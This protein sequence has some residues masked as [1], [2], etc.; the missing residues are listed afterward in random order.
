MARKTAS[1]SN[2]VFHDEF[3][4]P[5][6]GP[7]GIHRGRRSVAARFLPYLITIVVAIIV[8]LIV[9][10]WWGGKG[11]DLLHIN[12]TSSQSAA[13]SSKNTANDGSDAVSSPSN[14]SSSTSNANGTASN[15]LNSSNNSNGG[16]SSSS[17]S[18]NNSNSSNSP[19]GAQTSIRVYNGTGI[20]GLAAQKAQ[21]LKNAGYS[22]VVD[23]N[24]TD[25]YRPNV[26]TIWYR[27]NS[28]L[29][30]AQAIAQKL[31]INMVAQRP[32]IQVPIAIVY[33]RQ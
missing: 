27:N 15:G 24:L 20:S 10:A 25:G 22:Q 7:V 23:M 30:T 33:V 29:P 9:W 28:D 11:A 19:V 32:A 8:A 13:V 26:N 6:E 5:P 3:D 4:N 18:V 2:L 16:G 17:N 31:G 12:S 14:G 1:G 21:V